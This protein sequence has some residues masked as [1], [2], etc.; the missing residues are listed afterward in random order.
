MQKEYSE[1]EVF[2]DCFSLQSGTTSPPK[3]NKPGRCAVPFLAEH[4]CGS[5]FDNVQVMFVFYE[6]WSAVLSIVSAYEYT[7]NIPD[8]TERR[9]HII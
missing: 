8:I 1:K 5:H 6:I 7:S 3:W 9:P 4:H 2:S